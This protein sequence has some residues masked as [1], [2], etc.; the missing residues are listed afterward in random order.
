L[1]ATSRETVDTARPIKQAI[2]VKLSPRSSPPRISSRSL[3]ERRADDWSQ[4][5]GG[6]GA[7]LVSRTTTLSTAWRDRPIN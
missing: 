1:A 6:A 5:F 7:R 4:A 3:I 2:A